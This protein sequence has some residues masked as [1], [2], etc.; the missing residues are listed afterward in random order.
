[1]YADFLSANQGRQRDALLEAEKAER[2]DPLSNIVKSN[3]GEILTML[4]RFD[5]ARREYESIIQ[6]DPSFVRAHA[7]LGHMEWTVYGRLDNAI[8]QFRQAAA[9]DPGNVDYRGMLAVLWDE[10]GGAAE[11]DLSLNRARAVATGV[12]DVKGYEAWLKVARGNAADAVADAEAVL[13]EYPTSGFELWI[14]ALDYLRLDRAEIAVARYRSAYPTLMDDID[15]VI[16]FSNFWQAIDIAYVLKATGD[17]ALASL[18]LDRSMVFIQTIPRLGIGGHWYADARVFAIQGKNDRALVALRKAVDK[19]WRAEWEY[20]LKY[21]PVLEALH[22]EI[23]YRDIVAELEAD[24]VA[25]LK[26]VREMEANGE[27]A[28]IPE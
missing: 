2:L 15:P 9:L 25:Q 8:V 28:S 11:A 4:G 13:A 5:D 20:A 1:W 10:L 12:G 7:N 18:L 19:G 3:K 27:L 14:L 22:G 24:K 6:V 16:D 23:K 17:H 21:D 26:Q